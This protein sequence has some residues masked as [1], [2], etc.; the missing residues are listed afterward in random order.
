M[1]KDKKYKTLLILPAFNEELK[2]GYMVK[3][4][5]KGLIDE[6]LVV[7]D[8]STD[9]TSFKAREFGAKVIRHP[10]NMGVGAAIRTGIKYAL[11][12]KIEYILIMGGD[13][14]DKHSEA[15]NILR[16]LIEEGYDFVQGSRRFHG[17]RMINPPL[18]RVVATKMYTLLFRLLTGFPCTDATNGFRA[19]RTGIFYDPHININ[20]KWLNHYELEPYVLYKALKLKYRVKEVAVTKIYHSKKLGYS[21]MKPIISWWSILRPMILLSLG[22]KR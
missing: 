2:I 6:V 21:K 9:N 14:Q 7:D 11:D 20:Q 12:K 10:I 5:D 3:D 15:T 16:P 17:K 1:N 22:I 8:G 13:A 19:I 18:F 4:A